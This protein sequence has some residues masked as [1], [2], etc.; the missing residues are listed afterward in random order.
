MLYMHDYVWKEK[1][2][3]GNHPEGE[4]GARG[5]SLILHYTPFCNVLK[6]LLYDWKAFFLHFNISY[7][8]H[9]HMVY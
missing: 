5:R 8:K 4:P 7:L 2:N 1:G 9:I 6:F 3:S